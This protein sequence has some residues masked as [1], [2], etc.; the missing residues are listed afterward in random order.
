M[1]PRITPSL[2]PMLLV[3]K[4]T[5][6]KYDLDHFKCLALANLIVGP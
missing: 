1:L 4:L 3:F 2:W 5:L 6:V